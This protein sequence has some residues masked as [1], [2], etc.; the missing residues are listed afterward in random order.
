MSAL[1]NTPEWE[2]FKKLLITKRE[3]AQRRMEGV[4]DVSDIYKMQG[5]LRLIR[6][7]IEDVEDPIGPSDTAG[8]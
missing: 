5:R 6:E 8:V 2:Q 7:I 1:S 3:K 4:E